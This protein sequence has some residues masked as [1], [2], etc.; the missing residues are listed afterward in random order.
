MV[1]NVKHFIHLFQAKVAKKWDVQLFGGRFFSGSRKMM[2]K[3]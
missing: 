1:A 3:M 2:K